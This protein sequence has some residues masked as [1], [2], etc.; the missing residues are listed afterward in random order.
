MPRRLV[1]IQAVR[2]S[3]PFNIQG[4][5]R[6]LRGIQLQMHGSRCAYTSAGSTPTQRRLDEHE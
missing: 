4:T 6:A 2:S 1:K 3:T 5:I